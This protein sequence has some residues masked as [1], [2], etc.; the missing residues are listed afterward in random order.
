MTEKKKNTVD[1]NPR[2]NGLMISVAAGD[3]S[4]GFG[5][6]HEKIIYALTE[7]SVPDEFSQIAK[8]TPWNTRGRGRT[9]DELSFY[10]SSDDVRAEVLRQIVNLDVTIYIGTEINSPE[11]IERFCLWASRMTVFL[12]D[13]GRGCTERRRP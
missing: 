6:G 1:Y 8:M 2:R 13:R 4:G 7:T 9:E 10:S 11:R 12:P 3:D 5:T